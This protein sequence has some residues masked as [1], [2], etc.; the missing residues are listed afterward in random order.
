MAHNMA[1]QP[2]GFIV[3]AWT[4]LGHEQKHH[5]LDGPAALN[6]KTLENQ[7]PEL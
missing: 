3:A 7:S 1:P 5:H 6:E 2:D 4:R